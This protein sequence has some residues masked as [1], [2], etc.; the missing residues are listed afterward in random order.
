MATKKTT[1][2][3]NTDSDSDSD[4]GFSWV[5]G[6]NEEVRIT[7]TM[8]GGGSHWWNY[9]LIKQKDTIGKNDDYALY[10][11]SKEGLNYQWGNKLVFKDEYVKEVRD[12]YELKEDEFYYCWDC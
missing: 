8:A 9:V 3:N 11:E 12:N 4:D 10:I 7:L 2:Q 5:Y 1:T 6:C